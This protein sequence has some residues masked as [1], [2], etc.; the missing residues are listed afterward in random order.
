MTIARKAALYV[1]GVF[2][3]SSH[4]FSAEVEN[5]TVQNTSLSEYVCSVWTA[6]DGL[7]GNTVTDLIQGKNG[8]IYIGTYE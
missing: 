7:P 3:A 5:L 6:Q 4:A 2:F 1:L 8:Y